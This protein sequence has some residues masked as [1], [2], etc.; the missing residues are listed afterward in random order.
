MKKFLIKAFIIWRDIRVSY[1]NRYVG[2]RLG[3]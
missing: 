1:R 2:H 3:S